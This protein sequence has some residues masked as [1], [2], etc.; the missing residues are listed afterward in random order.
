MRE[1]DEQQ[2][3][4]RAG[5]C[6]HACSDRKRPWVVVWWW[7]QG[8]PAKGAA[9]L[10]ELHLV[11][12]TSFCS[13]LLILHHL[14]IPSLLFPLFLLFSALRQAWTEVLR[15][16]EGCSCPLVALSPLCPVTF[17]SDPSWQ[18][19]LVLQGRREHFNESKS[20]NPKVKYQSDICSPTPV[21]VV[22]LSAPEFQR[23]VNRQ[24]RGKSGTKTL[25]I[26]N[27]SISFLCNLLARVGWRRSDHTLVH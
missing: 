13:S 3:H 25:Q 17:Q 9:V 22:I 14:F 27:H 7:E 12:S 15:R 10:Q 19:R 1:G 8:A 21:T 4:R 6:Y 26:W 5:C 2:L 16:D 18:H 11:K 23:T 24:K 20:Q